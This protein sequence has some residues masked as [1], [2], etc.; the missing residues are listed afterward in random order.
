MKRD[1]TQK[2]SDAQSSVHK[3]K[4]GSL[5]W[6]SIVRN[7]WSSKQTHQR[8]RS[9]QR[10]VKREVGRGGRAGGEFSGWSS[11]PLIVCSCLYL[12]LYRQLEETAGRHS[13]RSLFQEQDSRNTRM[14]LLYLLFISLHHSCAEHTEAHFNRKACLRTRMKLILKYSFGAASRFTDGEKTPAEWVHWENSKAEPNPAQVIICFHF[15]SDV[16]YYEPPHLRSHSLLCSY[17]KGSGSSVRTCRPSDPK[18]WIGDRG[19]SFLRIETLEVYHTKRNR[20]KH[21]KLV[22]FIIGPRQRSSQSRNSNLPWTYRSVIYKHISTPH[23]QTGLLDFQVGFME[24]VW[25]SREWSHSMR[26][27]HLK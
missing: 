10:W 13:T 8:L 15:L 21:H 3:S 1:W 16:G 17:L 11:G 24:N 5:G 25:S 12:G 7:T 27:V 23:K 6:K 9:A 2:R 26:V 22:L 19:P 20:I 4:Q 14:C 18:R